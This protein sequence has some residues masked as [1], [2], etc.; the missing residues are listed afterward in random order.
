MKRGQAQARLDRLGIDALCD[1]I[2]AGETM[3]AVAASWGVSRGSV[4]NWLAASSER[5]ERARVARMMSAAAFDELAETAIRE[6]RDPFELAKARELAIHLRW[7][8]A[9]C[10]PGYSARF[11]AGA[12]GLPVVEEELDLM[13]TARRIA[14]ILN[15]AQRQLDTEEVVRLPSPTAKK[16]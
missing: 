16:T 3:S 10:D 14:F 9:K 1:R 2:V 12:T 15:R 11:A 6:A 4:V 13:E 8:A 5:G 7:R